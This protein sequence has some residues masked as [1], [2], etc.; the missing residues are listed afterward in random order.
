[1]DADTACGELL[2]RLIEYNINTIIS[3]VLND[4]TAPDEILEHLVEKKNA[5]GEITMLFC[6][7]LL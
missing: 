6:S 3:D 7:I 2:D 1:L 5:N 4:D